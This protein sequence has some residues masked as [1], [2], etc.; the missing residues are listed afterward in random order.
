[1]RSHKSGAM[2]PEKHSMGVDLSPCLG[3]QG[4][5]R[6]GLRYDCHPLTQEEKEVGEEEAWFKLGIPW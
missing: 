2:L 1:M 6:W 4:W 3:H 5:G